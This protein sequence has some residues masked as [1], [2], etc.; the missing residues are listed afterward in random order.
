MKL[1]MG[2]INRL[3][4]KTGD[5]HFSS[6]FKMFNVCRMRKTPKNTK[7]WTYLVLTTYRL[8]TSI[9]DTVVF[10]EALY[11]STRYKLRPT[12]PRRCICEI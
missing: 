9:P 6:E 7:N 2:K 10:T 11:I 3:E 12:E 8:R 5:I 4:A 1:E